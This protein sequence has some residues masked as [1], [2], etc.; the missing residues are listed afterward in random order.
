MQNTTMTK[1][2]WVEMFRQIG[3][4]EAQMQQ[5]HQLFEQGYPTQHQAFLEWLQIPA[6]EIVQIREASKA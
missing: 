4:S 6:S 1:A 5:W 3:L 2:A